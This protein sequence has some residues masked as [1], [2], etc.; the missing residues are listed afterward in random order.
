MFECIYSLITLCGILKFTSIPLTA[1]VFNSTLRI[2]V[3]FF[4]KLSQSHLIQT[5]WSIRPTDM[6]SLSVI[7]LNILLLILSASIHCIVFSS[8]SAIRFFQVSTWNQTSARALSLQ[9]AFIHV[10]LFH[11]HV[12]LIHCMSCFS[13]LSLNH[14]YFFLYAI[15]LIWVIISIEYFYMYSNA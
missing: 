11:L 7:C 13:C 9:I 1:I 12:T 2:P 8:S 5:T 3:D 14:Y 4:S 10:F 15:D 6:N